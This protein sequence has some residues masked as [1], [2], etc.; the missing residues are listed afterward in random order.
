MNIRNI[1]SK[2]S[3]ILKKKR[4]YAY[5]MIPFIR[6]PKTVCVFA[7]VSVGVGDIRSKNINCL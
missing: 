7:D 4:T 6:S 3:Q 1:F 2:S 5:Y